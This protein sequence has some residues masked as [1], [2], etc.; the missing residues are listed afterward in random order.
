MK[1]E[2]VS[3]N[4]YR[5]V[6]E[7]LERI[8]N[9]AQRYMSENYDTS[10]QFRLV[11]SG[12]NHLI[13]RLNDGNKGFDFDYNLIL[14]DLEDGYRYNAKVV[15]KQFLEAFDFA[16][17][18]TKYNHPEDSTS[19][20]TIKNVSTAKSK[21]IH[22]CDF[23]I[24]YYPENNTDCGYMYIKKLKNGGYSFEMRAQSKKAEYKLETVCEQKNGWNRIREEY[25]KLKNRNLDPDKH[26]YVLYLEAINNMYNQIVQ[27]GYPNQLLVIHKS[28][29]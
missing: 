19:V 29:Y 25:L 5:P 8:I 15:K 27:V 28:D 26:S 13:T 24:I 20:I 6:R 4:E 17:K 21:I 23:A 22:S 1:Y 16:I 2:Y 10:F 7:E 12:N 3:K 9:R 18:G 14:P 11:G